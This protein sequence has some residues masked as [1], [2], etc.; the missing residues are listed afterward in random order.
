M[1]S[2]AAVD[3]MSA[4]SQKARLDV[5]RTLVRAGDDGATPSAILAETDIGPTGL[6]FHLKTLL[7][8]G[9]VEVEAAGRQR[10]YRANYQAMRELVSFLTEACCTGLTVAPAEFEGEKT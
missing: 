4:L 1:K 3:I 6:S 8:A 5:F 2:E 9:L 10:I 7:H